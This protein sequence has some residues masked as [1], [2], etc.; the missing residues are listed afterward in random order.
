MP[1]KIPDDLPA[2]EILNRENIFI[3]DETRAYTQDIRPL[4][5]LI[6]NLMP[7]KVQTETQILRLLGNTPLQVDVSFI[8]PDTHQSKNTSFEHLKTFYKTIDEVKAQKF[9]GMIITGAPVEKLAFEQVD[10]WTELK[11]IMDWSLTN[12]TSTLHICW[13]AQAGLYHHYGIEKI[14]TPK[15]VFGVFTHQVLEPTI[16]LLRGFD[17]EFLAPHSRHTDICLQQVKE[18]PDLQVLSWSDEAGLYL[19]SSRNGKQ[20]FVTGHSEYDTDTLQQEY[21]RDKAKG[22]N[23]QLPIN[24]FPDNQEGKLPKL[25]WRAHSN[26]LFSNW[27]NYYVY[28][29]TPY[30]FTI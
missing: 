21:E 3:M 26:L 4:K 10:Y 18:H 16:K 25:R 23:I 24:Y 8:H 2:K 22:M 7:L 11:M 13:G 28:Q 9:D 5:I 12:V 19:C 17:E 27:L 29:E 15:K 6:L 14:A 1:I 30:D 20:I